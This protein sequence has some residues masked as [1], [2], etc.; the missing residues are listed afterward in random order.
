MAPIE[1]AV[2]LLRPSARNREGSLGRYM[3]SSHCCSSPASRSRGSLAVTS[4]PL[5]GSST[6]GHQS[7]G[8]WWGRQ[9]MYKVRLPPLLHLFYRTDLPAPKHKYLLSLGL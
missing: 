6:R 7:A 1:L 2:S 4:P 3:Q 9:Y 5:K 8:M